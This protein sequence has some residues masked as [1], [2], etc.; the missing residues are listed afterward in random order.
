MSLFTISSFI[1]LSQC[2][3]SFSKLRFKGGGVE[4]NQNHD[5]LLDSS[6]RSTFKKIK[7]NL[8]QRKNSVTTGTAPTPST[9][10]YSSGVFCL[11]S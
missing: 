10:S 7:L 11:S 6:L 2:Y 1:A 9:S 5:D 8:E 3:I 4:K